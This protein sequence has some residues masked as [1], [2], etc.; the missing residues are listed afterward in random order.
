MVSGALAGWPP[1]A[2]SLGTQKSMDESV[3]RLSADAITVALLGRSRPLGTVLAGLLFGRC[4]PGA[5]P[6][7]APGTPH[8]GSS[9]VCSHDRAVCRRAA[10]S[11]HLPRLPERRDTSAAHR[12]TPQCRP[13]PRPLPPREGGLSHGRINRFCR[14]CAATAP[15]ASRA[16]DGSAHGSERLITGVVVR[17]AAAGSAAPEGPAARNL[18][19]DR[20]LRPLSAPRPQA[21]HR[22]VSHHRWDHRG[23]HRLRPGPASPRDPTWAVVLIG[24]G[25]VLAPGLGG[26]QKSRH[27]PGDRLILPLGLGVSRLRAGW[28]IGE[29]SRAPSTSPS[30]L[31]PGRRLPGAVVASAST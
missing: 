27:P 17:S 2:R 25:F 8:Q 10:W 29:R 6:Q 15:D 9:L 13:Q 19:P 18:R 24:I 31:T 22:T 11:G 1:T 28:I 5:P 4:A 23:V 14:L 3:V 26:G 30:G 21:Q 16:R 7:A 12:R 20:L